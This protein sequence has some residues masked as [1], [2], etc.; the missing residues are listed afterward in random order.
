MIRIRTIYD[1]D[2]IIRLI[3]WDIAGGDEYHL[4]R[5]SFYRESS[6]A[7]IVCSLE[8]NEL[9]RESFTHIPDWHSILLKYR[10]QIPIYLF[11][12]KVDLVNEDMLDDMKMKRLV[13]ENNFHGYYYTS[14][15]SEQSVIKAFN[16]ISMELYTKIKPIALKERKKKK[17]KR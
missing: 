9:G 16:D 5:P 4:L 1:V 6:A 14:V 15:E 10:G 17:Q 8:D 7:I 3:F 2:N 12:N 11:A 13:R